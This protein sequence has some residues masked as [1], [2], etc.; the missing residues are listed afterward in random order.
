MPPNR[1]AFLVRKHAP[2]VVKDAPYPTPGDNELVI[3]NAAVAMNPY[4]WAI[5]E[6]HN[7]VVPWVKLP[8]IIGTDVAGEVVAVGKSVT[9]FRPGDRVLG[10]AI[11]LAKRIN[12]PAEAAFQH[13]T[14]LRPDMTATIPSSMTYD[15]AAVIPLGISTAACALF[16]KDFLNLPYPTA[17]PK[18]TG[19]TVLVWGGSSSVGSNAIQLAVA[20][21][22]EVIST[23]SPKNHAMLKK[24]GAAEVFDYRSPTVV[25]DIVA[26][27][28]GRT[29]AG[30]ISIGVGSLK[31]CTEVLGQVKGVKFIAQASFDMTYFPKGTL[32]LPG[33]MASMVGGMIAANISDLY[34]SDVGKAIYNDFLP[35]ALAGGQYV[36]APDPEIVGHGLE[37]IQGA[38]MQQKKGVSAE[39]LVVTL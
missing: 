24:L 17:N 27:F 7:F 12:R 10:H 23:A 1:A 2:L 33:F 6:A 9:R 35:R 38:M 25:R 22:Y 32:E 15:H 8:G 31:A 28:K 18:P 5:Q 16:E 14:V 29:S 34:F 36:A 20:A 19:K 21:G 13:Y 4:E 39:K 37:V 26:A 3:K 11:G 30:A